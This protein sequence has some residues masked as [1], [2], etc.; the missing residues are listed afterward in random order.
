MADALGFLRLQAAEL[1][2]DVCFIGD[3]F[4]AA[5]LG[6]WKARASVLQWG[7]IGGGWALVTRGLAPVVA[8]WGL[9]PWPLSA[10]LFLL[11]L[12]GWKYLRTLFSAG[13]YTLRRAK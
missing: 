1:W 11:S 6:V 3:L 9:E 5:T 2:A 7:A 13:V 8:W 4:A 10:G 12:A